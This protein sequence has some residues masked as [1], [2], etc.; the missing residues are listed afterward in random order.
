MRVILIQTV[1]HVLFMNYFLK[2][3]TRFNV[4]TMVQGL[5]LYVAKEEKPERAQNGKKWCAESVGVLHTRNF[6]III[7]HVIFLIL[8][9]I[10]ARKL[11]LI[12]G[13]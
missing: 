3:L 13:K 7:S 5:S 1:T 2:H 10:Y 4:F 8:R 11:S 9:D 6:G 12:E